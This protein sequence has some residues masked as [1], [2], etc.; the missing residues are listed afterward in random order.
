MRQ[1]LVQTAKIDYW[2]SSQ[3]PLSAGEKGLDEYLLV[4][5][6]EGDVYDKVMTIE[7]RFYREY[8]KEKPADIRPQIVLASFVSSQELEE[9]LIRWLYRISSQQDSFLVT[10]NN[11][12]G[13]LTHTIYLRILDHRPFQNLLTQLK[14]IE[15]YVLANGGHNLK[16]MWPHIS[17]AR[18]LEPE[19][20]HKAMRAYSEKTFS[21]SFIAGKLVLLRRDQATGN[22]QAVCVFKLRP[23]Q[24]DLSN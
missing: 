6:P 1:E 24:N 2:F 9:T 11:Y 8:E 22:D 13:F 21:E 20:F 16:F 10:L 18:Q 5:Q 7:E 3:D 4:I 23:G 17:I 12:S 14:A 15:P 19:V